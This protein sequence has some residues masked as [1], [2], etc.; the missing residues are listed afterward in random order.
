[1]VVVEHMVDV[2]YDGSQLNG[3]P[4]TCP[5]FDAGRVKVVCI[6]INSLENI[7]SILSWCDFLQL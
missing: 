6:D 2:L 3:A 1:M 4:F 7:A 5:V